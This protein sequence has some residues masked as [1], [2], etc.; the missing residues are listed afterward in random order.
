MP[1]SRA[2]VPTQSASRF[3]QQLCKHWSHKFEVEYTPDHGTIPFAADRKCFLEAAA[4]QLSM[5]IEAADEATLIRMEGAGH[6]LGGPELQARVMAFFDKHL[7]GRAVEV[8]AEPIKVEPK[9]Q[10]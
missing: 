3:L 6:A 9:T 8:S 1:S 5:R 2:N 4:N 7:K 10:P